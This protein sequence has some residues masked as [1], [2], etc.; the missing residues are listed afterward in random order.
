MKLSIL[1]FSAFISLI[2]C[3]DVP[4]DETIVQDII[5]T[6]DNDPFDDSSG[7]VTET[8]DGITVTVTAPLS[9]H[10]HSVGFMEIV[11]AD[12]NSKN[13]VVVS[14]HQE[15]SI[16]FTFSIPVHVKSIVAMS[17]ENRNIT[18]TFLPLEDG[19]V[20]FTKN[21]TRG[22]TVAAATVDFNWTL[23][24]SFTVTSSYT[25]FGFDFL[26]VSNPNATVL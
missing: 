17:G 2:G 23:I 26:V 21:L 24:T 8:V 4:N 11:D 9:N 19:N 1:F 12:A 25:L 7:T 22:K 16:K 3:S 10:K 13:N 18:Y 14:F 20:S 5:F 6:W 15:T